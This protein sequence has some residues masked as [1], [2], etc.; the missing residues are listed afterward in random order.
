MSTTWADRLFLRLAAIYGHQKL[1]AMWPSDDQEV[2]QTWEEQ[3]RRFSPEVLRKAIQALLDAGREWPPTLP[4]FV[5]ICRQFTRPEQAD[6]P[7]A[8]PPPSASEV[9]TAAKQ[10]QSIAEVVTKPPG[11]DY[12]SWARR[13][14]SAQAVWLLQREA[15]HDARLLDILRQHVADGGTDCQ[16]D[17]ARDAVRAI[18]LEPA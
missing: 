7:V 15:Q 11:W 2:R 16:S 18:R 10:L 1:S 13:P 5:A 6:V 14:K 3:L 4:E 8:L 9:A 17:E 12:L